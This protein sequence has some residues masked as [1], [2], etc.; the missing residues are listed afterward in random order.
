MVP[1]NVN[2]KSQG[3]VLMQTKQCS[4]CVSA[5]ILRPRRVSL[6]R[7]CSYNWRNMFACWC[8]QPHFRQ[9]KYSC[10][11]VCESCLASSTPP[12][13]RALC[14]DPSGI[15]PVSKDAWVSEKLTAVPT[16]LKDQI[17][18]TSTANYQGIIRAFASHS[19]FTR[20]YSLKKKKRK[21]IHQPFIRQ[22][23]QALWNTL[24]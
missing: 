13:G 15:F 19:L 16:F 3:E 11:A 22:M 23:K 10:S 8:K 4:R 24:K 5:A 1:K 14:H 21:A 6:K 9:K 7:L 17:L 12:C 18:K 2:S 20:L